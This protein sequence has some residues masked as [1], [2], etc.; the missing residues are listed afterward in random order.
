L[1][2]IDYPDIS[3]I[4][5]FSCRACEVIECEW[6]EQAELLAQCTAA[7]R[8]FDYVVSLDVF[9]H[10]FVP[11]EFLAKAHAIMKR[12]AQLFLMLPLAD[13]LPAYHRCWNAREHVYVHSAQH[14]VMML[15]N[16]GF[17]N[18]K[19][20]RWAVGHDTISARKL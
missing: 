16:A 19:F 11:F 15:K 6:P 13:E 3:Q 1:K 4:D 17:G 10:S 5:T 12:G 18:L 9:E 8:P 14:M 2:G 7:I 20:D